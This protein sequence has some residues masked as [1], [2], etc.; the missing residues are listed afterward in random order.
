MEVAVGLLQKCNTAGQLVA[1]GRL[2]AALRLLL[3][4]KAQLHPVRTSSM[5]R[6]VFLSHHN[7]DA[8]CV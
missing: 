3:S 6:S 2:P 4:V 5:P 1:E 7:S 8:I